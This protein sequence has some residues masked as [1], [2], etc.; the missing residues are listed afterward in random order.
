MTHQPT[1][2]ALRAAAYWLEAHPD[3]P[4]PTVFVRP[5]SVV[6]AWTFR[7]RQA[8]LDLL[9]DFNGWTFE[10]VPGST[11]GFYTLDGGGITLSIHDR[12]QPAQVVNLLDALA[13]VA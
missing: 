10:Q 2:D 5:D 13:E 11:T 6:L 12:S 4:T 9:R 1:L 7:V 3:L 8:V